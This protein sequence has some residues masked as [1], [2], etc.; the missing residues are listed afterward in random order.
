MPV[1]L[2]A[3]RVRVVCERATGVERAQS[4]FVNGVPNGET[5]LGQITFGVTDPIPV[6]LEIT[7][8]ATVLT[9]IANGAQ[10]VTTGSLADGTL[11]DLTLASTGT[12]YLASNSAIA[13]VS[14]DGFVLAVSSGNVLIT[15]THEGVIATIALSVELSTDADG[16]S[17]PDD[18]EQLNAVNTG[19]ANLSRLPGTQVTA[20][21]FSGSFVPEQAIDGNLF[22]SWFTGVD[23]RLPEE[24]RTS[25]AY[26]GGAPAYSAKC[27][28]EAASGYEGF[29]L[30]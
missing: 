14:A 20:S 10:L 19:G 30:G 1:P 12:F 2:G 26:A 15:A 24:R 23:Q 17:I 29:V 25:L 9:P 13:T 11:I 16:D 7:S 18:F 28:E 8:P 5:P 6:F 27:E 3:F 21:S 4:P 22:T